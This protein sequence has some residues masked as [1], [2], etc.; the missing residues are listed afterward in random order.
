MSQRITIEQYREAVNLL[1]GVFKQLGE[2]QEV[3]VLPLLGGV[4]GAGNIH[5]ALMRL[6][7]MAQQLE[8]Q[9]APKAEESTVET[10]AKE[11]PNEDDSKYKAGQVIL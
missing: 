1:A 4:S 7:L 3:N 8:A 10:V 6:N 9:S 5:M 11:A 2:Q